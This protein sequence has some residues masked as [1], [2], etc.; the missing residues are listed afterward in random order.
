MGGRFKAVLFDL[1]GTVIRNE[2][3]PR[4]FMRIFEANGTRV[5]FE[6]VARAHAACQRELDTAEMARMGHDYW[7]QWNLKLLKRLGLI[8]DLEALARKIDREW[9][10]YAKIEPYPDA[11][12]TLHKLKALGVKTG[13]VTNG[14]RRDYE[15]IL[16][17]TGLKDQFDVA[18]GVDDCHAAKPDRRIFTH[19][20]D[21][22]NVRP[23]EAIFIG[24]SREYDYEGAK[25]AGLKP[26]L[27]IRS[28]K[29]SAENDTIGNLAEA[30]HF[31]NST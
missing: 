26:L 10:D 29:H 5:R 2:E 3:P 15:T 13:I 24:D 7:I 23:E 16:A 19:A 1:G 17:K 9:F 25:Q 28:N 22:L 20:L 6:D 18:V 11:V 21:K 31:L 30:L 27:I 8:G 12:E 4:V 14:L